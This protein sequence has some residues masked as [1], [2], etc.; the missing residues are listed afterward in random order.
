[1]STIRVSWKEGITSAAEAWNQKS[2]CFQTNAPLP[3]IQK[4][5]ESLKNDS[6]PSSSKIRTLKQLVELQGYTFEA[7]PA[8]AEITF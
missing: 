7:L 8:K 3:E 6:A 2:E 4:I 5:A 1:M